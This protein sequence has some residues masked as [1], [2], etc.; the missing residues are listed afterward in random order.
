LSVAAQLTAALVILD[1]TAAALRTSFAGTLTRAITAASAHDPL[2][3]GHSLGEALSSA[4]RCAAPVMAV[5]TGA[6]V[7]AHLAQTRFLLVWPRR[8]AETSQAQPLAAALS[9]GVVSLAALWGAWRAAHGA[10]P[11]RS[12]PDFVATFRRVATATI[13]HAAMAMMGLGVLELLWRRATFLR[14]MTPTWSEARRER[15]EREG[16]PRVRE[17]Q[18]RMHRALSDGA[19]A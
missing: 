19:E 10:L 1:T 6:L 8:I 18:R 2:A 3:P 11:P 17:T 5:A 13:E 16:D 15:R 7:L 4:L 9:Y 14:A 12:A